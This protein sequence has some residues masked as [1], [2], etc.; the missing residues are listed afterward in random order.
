MKE[1]IVRLGAVDENSIVEIV[2]TEDTEWFTSDDERNA[3]IGLKV[4]VKLP[5][6]KRAECYPIDK[7]QKEQLSKS[8]YRYIRECVNRFNINPELTFVKIIK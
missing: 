3:I 1:K 7:A 6:W 2:S 5:C 4:R 8:K